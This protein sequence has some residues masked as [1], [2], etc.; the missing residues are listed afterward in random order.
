[1][2]LL[3]SLLVT[4]QEVGP[5]S[6]HLSADTGSEAVD[7]SGV[8][9]DLSAVEQSLESAGLCRELEQLLPLILGKRGLLGDGALSVL[10]LALLLPLGDLGLLTL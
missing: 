6:K 5:D 4:G 10:G 8:L 3:A 2:P 7:L 9:L 1:M